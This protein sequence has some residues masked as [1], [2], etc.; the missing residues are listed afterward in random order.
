MEK[1]SRLVQSVVGYTREPL[2]V[3]TLISRIFY[4][5]LPDMIAGPNK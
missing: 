3:Q 2:Y 4:D 1:T 5:D